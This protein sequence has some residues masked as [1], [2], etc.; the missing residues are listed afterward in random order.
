MVWRM[1]IVSPFA[2]EFGGHRITL[3]LGS[4]VS[5][6]GRKGDVVGHKKTDPF[7]LRNFTPTKSPARLDRALGGGDGQMGLFWKLVF[8]GA[9][10]RN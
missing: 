1:H 4:G 7:V 10:C 9:P 5:L 8:G 2:V 6:G 3:S